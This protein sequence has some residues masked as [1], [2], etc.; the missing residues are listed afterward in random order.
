MA[1]AYSS[2][3]VST[4]AL[5][6]SASAGLIAGTETSLP[7]GGAE[8][9]VVTAANRC[10]AGLVGLGLGRIAGSFLGLSGPRPVAAGQGDTVLR[11]AQFL[12]Q[13]GE[14]HLEPARRIRPGQAAEVHDGLAVGAGGRPQEHAAA[15]DH[16][17]QDQPAQREK[18]GDQRRKLAGV[19]SDGQADPLAVAGEGE[20]A[21]AVRQGDRL[22]DGQRSRGDGQLVHTG[23]V[24]LV[25]G[26]GRPVV[27]P[28]VARVGGEASGTLMTPSE[29]SPDC[30]TGMN[31]TGP[32]N[33]TLPAPSVTLNSGAYPWPIR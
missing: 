33:T 11:S 2:T 14:L 19:M 13:L 18:R 10:A 23:G 6:A 17:R 27:Q 8:G 25:D 30:S 31:G 15:A 21:L 1:S 4:R 28:E 7:L 29:V 32:A 20:L 5:L 3:A 9:L 26:L 16:E 22:A 12:G 24:E